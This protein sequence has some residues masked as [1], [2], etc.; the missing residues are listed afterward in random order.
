MARAKTA[1]S[2]VDDDGSKDD[3]SASLWYDSASEVVLNGEVCPLCERR[4]ISDGESW[5]K[6]WG[7]VYVPAKDQKCPWIFHSNM[8]STSPT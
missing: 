8:C 2:S 6:Y 5:Q 3:T 1:F 4:D 7:R